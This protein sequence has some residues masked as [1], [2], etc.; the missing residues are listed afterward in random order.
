MYELYFS[1]PYPLCLTH[2]LS[3]ICFPF[4]YKCERENTGKTE[5]GCM[6][7]GGTAQI[8]N[9]MEGDGIF[10]RDSESVLIK[11]GM[12][13]NFRFSLEHSFEEKEKNPKYKK[14]H[15]M[16]GNMTL[17]IN[18]KEMG[19]FNHPKNNKMNT[20]LEDGTVNPDYKGTIYV[21]VKCD[22]DCNC[23]IHQHQPECEINAELSF[24]DF[25]GST[26]GYHND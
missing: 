23:D 21:D 7:D 1:L 9:W 26:Y 5:W 6:H 2:F 13:G 15:K 25:K 17:S 4:Y 11:N 22:S 10:S 19:T 18:D 14:D 3:V 20:H 12:N 16:V 24:T 8:S